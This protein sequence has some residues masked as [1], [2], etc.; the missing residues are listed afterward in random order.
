VNLGTRNAD[1][2]ERIGGRQGNPDTM[3]REE[4]GNERKTTGRK[5]TSGDGHGIGRAIKTWLTEGAPMP[6]KMGT[7]GTLRTVVR[8][9]AKLHGTKTYRTMK[10]ERVTSMVTPIR[11]CATV[12]GNVTYKTMIEEKVVL[13]TNATRVHGAPHGKETCKT[14]TEEQIEMIR[15]MVRMSAKPHG[16]ETYRTMTEKAQMKLKMFIWTI[17]NQRCPI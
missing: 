4:I 9:L 16:K 5:K 17:R 14:M 6:T 12:H 10:E 13:A 15:A 2:S 8:L 3:V 1:G 7:I 11:I